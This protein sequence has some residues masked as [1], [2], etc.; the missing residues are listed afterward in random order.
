MCLCVVFLLYRTF[1]II[2]IIRWYVTSYAMII[3]LGKNQQP[4][5]FHR[6]EGSSKV[7]RNSLLST[8]LTASY[9]WRPLSWNF[10]TWNLSRS[11]HSQL[12]VSSRYA[13]GQLMV[14]SRSPHVILMVSSRYAYA[15]LMVRSRSPDGILMV[16]S[17]Y[18]YGQVM[19]RSRSPHGTLL[20][21]LQ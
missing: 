19:V 7:L 16:S 5:N 4:P 15:Q 12:T 6:K 21:S 20:F 8:K 1:Y 3:M 2:G 17:K 10:F 9:S 13:H 11:A 14:C 18:A